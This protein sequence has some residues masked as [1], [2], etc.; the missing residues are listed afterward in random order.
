MGQISSYH[1]MMAPDAAARRRS[2][3][4]PTAANALHYFHPAETPPSDPF[5][6]VP[7][8]SASMPHSMLWVTDALYKGCT[9][10]W[11]QRRAIRGCDECRLILIGGTRAA[12]KPLASFLVALLVA[13][14]GICGRRRVQVASLCCSAMLW[15][16]NDLL[17]VWWEHCVPGKVIRRKL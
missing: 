16:S 6:R 7:R 14:S 4:D 15:L 10:G 8:N 3:C 9:R 13:Q 1:L 5:L 11:R 17:M 12:E 2:S